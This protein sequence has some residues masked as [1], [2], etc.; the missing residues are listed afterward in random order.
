MRVGVKMTNDE[1]QQ[2]LAMK[3]HFEE[4]SIELPNPGEKAVRPFKVLSDTTKDVFFVDTDRKSTIVLSKKKLQER[5]M[6][7]NTVMIRLEID[8]VPHMYR[9]GTRSSRNHIHIFDEQYG[10]VTYD[11]S[12]EYGKLFSNINDFVSVFYDFCNMCNIKTDNVNIQG[13]I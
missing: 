8:C 3:K 1:F 7:S 13:V 12:G 9:D 4:H 11:L 10:N 5:H 2:L 6:N